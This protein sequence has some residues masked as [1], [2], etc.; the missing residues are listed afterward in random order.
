M[1]ILSS[2]LVRD[3]IADAGNPRL[4]RVC[5]TMRH[6]REPQLIRDTIA[7]ERELVSRVEA[8]ACIVKFAGFHPTYNN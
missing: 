6:R 8:R 5:Q 7:D 3:C 2:T 4:R 1:V